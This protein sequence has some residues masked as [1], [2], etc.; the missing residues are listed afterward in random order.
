M[1]N[2][3]FKYNVEGPGYIERRGEVDDSVHQG[4][5]ETE[6]KLHYEIDWAFIEAMAKRMAINKGKYPPEN[7]KKPMDTANLT[8]PL[9]RHFVEVMK[10]N[11]ND[12]TEL[13]HIEA[14][15]CNAMMLWYQIKYH[16]K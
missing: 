13:G 11:Y 5:K 2:R 7:W 6:G 1:D 9:T 4:I 10:G 12:E 16:S 3:S 8:Q 15:A 14:L